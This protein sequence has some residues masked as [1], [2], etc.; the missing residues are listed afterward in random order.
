MKLFIAGA[1]LT[2]FLCGGEL[3]GQPAKLDPTFNPGAGASG[4][5][6]A[7]NVQADGQIVV[8]G[9]FYSFDGVPRRFV[10][11]L[12]P[13]GTV[14]PD[15][16]PQQR[17]DGTLTS[18]ATEPT[19]KIYIAGDFSA[20]NSIPRSY[21]ARLRSDGSLDVGWTN[22]VFN[23]SINSIYR[24]SDGKI[25]TIGSFSSVAGA[26]RK[27]VARLNS[28]SSLDT[29]NP[30]S[31]V[32]GGSVEAIAIQTDGKVIIAGN[33][34]TV[35]ATNRAYIARVSSSGAFDPTF[36]PGPIGGS[37]IH[38]LVLKTDGNIIVAGSFSSING[39]SRIGIARLQTNG[40]V[41]VSFVLP[42][43][44]SGISVLAL[45]PDQ[46]I[47][48]GGAFSGVGTVSQASLARLNIN[49]SVD[50]SFAADIPC[51]SSYVN[52]MALQPDGKILVGGTFTSITGTNIN[53]I[54]RLNGT[55]AGGVTLTPGT[56]FGMQL[57]GVVSNSYRIEYTSNPATN[58]LWSP[59]NT[60]TLAD[61]NQLVVDPVPIKSKD[62][63][64]YRAVNLG[65]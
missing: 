28:D 23:S 20:F 63:R 52:A 18:I 8:C 7:I 56:Y 59:L 35:G 34:A 27:G 5:V 37:S 46:K 49:G 26:S 65:P 4:N 11:R 24:Q 48:L 42:N 13:F 21:F 64:F 38:A 53:R 30:A 32:G 57:N 25:L 62:F 10:A 39:Y 47:L 16:D 44:V 51:C 61:P 60:V 58:G 36:D 2:C 12:S 22:I 33:F 50:T 45:Q 17:P 41:D 31:G 3:Q 29:F 14:D 54:A 55:S 9:G 19:G 6:S 40:A 43:G 15:F 1:L